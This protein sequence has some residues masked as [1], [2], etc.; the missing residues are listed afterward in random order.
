MGLHRIRKGLD[1]PI[2]GKPAQEIGAAPAPPMVAL[3]ADDYVGMKPTMFVG[4]GDSV[5]RGQALFE[6]K[7]TAG[8]RYTAP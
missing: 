1:L 2:S 5:R 4:V 8:V 7:K 6:D 3:L